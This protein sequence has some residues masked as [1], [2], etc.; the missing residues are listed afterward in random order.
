[1]R[2]S[3][4]TPRS[5]GLALVLLAIVSGCRPGDRHGRVIVL[6]LDGM[7]PDVV[8]RLMAEGALP[9]FR[10]LRDGGAS[11]R[12]RSS[13]PLLSPIIWTTIATG[14]PPET[15]G[16]G[17]FVATDPQTGKQLPVTSRMRRV[18]ALCW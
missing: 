8:E 16:I 3:A 15:H 6:G 5:L 14:K 10:Q 11:G 9:H 4:G 1:M 2:A 12:L 13:P 18:K 7:D 17:H